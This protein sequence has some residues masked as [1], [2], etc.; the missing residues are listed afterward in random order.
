MPLRLVLLLVV[1]FFTSHGT[2]QDTARN[3]GVVMRYFEEVL[4][5]QR[6]DVVAEI[7]AADYVFVNLKDGS[8]YKGTEQ[9]RKFLPY[10]FK[11]F[12][13]I[14]YTVNRI[15]ANNNIVAIEATASGT[16]IS[17]FWGFAPM[18]NKIRVTEIFFYTLANGKI[19][20]GRVLLDVDT[21]KSQLGNAAGDK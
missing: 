13:D 16:H 5:K 15:V 1:T 4:N 9:L 6:V 2:A 19:V 12:P 7:F 18:R 20:E 8:G 21:L 17:E 11:A 3:K 14:R 10:L